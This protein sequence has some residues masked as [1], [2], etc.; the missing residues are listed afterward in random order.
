MSMLYVF[1]IV[2]LSRIELKVCIF[3]GLYELSNQGYTDLDCDSA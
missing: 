3:L 2:L 1:E